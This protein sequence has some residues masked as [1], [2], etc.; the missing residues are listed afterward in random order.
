[1]EFQF[2]LED[3]HQMSNG[4][5]K[6]VNNILLQRNWGFFMISSILLRNQSFIILGSFNDQ[7]RWLRYFLRYI[8]RNFIILSAQKAVPRTIPS[9]LT[10]HIHVILFLLHFFFFWK[11]LNSFKAIKSS[12][13]AKKAKAYMELLNNIMC[14][15]T[16]IFSYC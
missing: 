12:G 10:H 13:Q 9:L 2:V 7:G 3:K 6:N 5:H 1:M 4:D 16:M 8:S 11:T 14:C 15:G